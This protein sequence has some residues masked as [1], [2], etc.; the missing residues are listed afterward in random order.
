MRIRKRNRIL[1]RLVLG[2]AVAALVVPGTAMARVDEG[3]RQSGS[4]Q[5]NV[6]ANAWQLGSDGRWVK[7]QGG[8]QL[9][10]P[11]YG[12]EVANPAGV[13]IADPKYG[14]EIANPGGVQIAD[15]KY[16]Q[17]IANPGGV[18][19]ADPKFGQETQ[20][21]KVG[22]YG[23]PPAGLNVYL[24]THSGKALVTPRGSEV[25]TQTPQVVS[26]GGF[27]WSDAGI[28]AG[29]IAG[30]VLL[31]AG[32]LFTTRQFGRAQTA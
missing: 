6:A 21:V 3:T 11:K 9:A 27:D 20:S 10:D 5:S 4:G 8:V 13:Q 2:F 32:A 19:I 18:Q 28:G 16:G 22:T 17:E 26:S 12:Q 14:Q 1:R 30:I 25:H 7:D 24:E 15:P 23:M 31:G 29:V